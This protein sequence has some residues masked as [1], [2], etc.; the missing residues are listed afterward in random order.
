MDD[1]VKPLSVNGILPTAKSISS[2]KYAIAR[3]LYMFTDAYP[4][5][6]SDIYN[7]VTLHLSNEGREIIK[8][9]GYIPVCE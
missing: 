7:F 6:G 9:L 3:P 8:D 1:T 2:G 5:M 4:K